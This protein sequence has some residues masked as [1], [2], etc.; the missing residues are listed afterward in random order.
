[1]ISEHENVISENFKRRHDIKRY[2]FKN[3]S[4]RNADNENTEQTHEGS[5]PQS[6][7]A[8]EAAPEPQEQS[9]P[10]VDTPALKLFEEEVVDKILQKSDELAN[11]LSALQAQFDKQNAEMESKIA[12]A[13]EESKA[14]GEQIGYEK[15]KSELSAQHKASQELYAE[16]IKKLENAIATQKE[17]IQNL[18]KE[19]SS[20]SLDIAQEVIACEVGERPSKIASALARSLLGSVSKGVQTTIKVN[21]ADLDDLKESLSDLQ[22][23]T[24]EAD[25]AIA[26]GGCVLMS[27]EGNIDGDLNLRFTALK[28]SILEN[29]A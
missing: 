5:A 2:N 21:P 25:R 12:A 1:M 4:D 18:E 28:K 15:A 10:V 8:L 6:T 13:K 11:N 29:K 22:N 9:T 17:Y 19:L 16:S 27:A 23:I 26:R 3:M 24:L 14:A 7:M 20:I